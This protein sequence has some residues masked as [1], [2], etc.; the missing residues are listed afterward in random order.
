MSISSHRSEP[1]GSLEAKA[2]QGIAKKPHSGVDRVAAP[3]PDM[4]R[5][6]IVEI[7][8]KREIRK[9]RMRKSQERHCR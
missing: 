6:A 4:L 1:Q 2:R 9:S 8:K 5:L 3:A 7:A